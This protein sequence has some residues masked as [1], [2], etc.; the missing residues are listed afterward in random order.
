M[1]FWAWPLSSDPMLH[2][3]FSSLAR[4]CRHASMLPHL[5]T[6]E[7]ALPRRAKPVSATTV[8]PHNA[9]SGGRWGCRAE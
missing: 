8:V 4:H 3:S 5:R 7:R 1:F 6:S 9:R 2:P